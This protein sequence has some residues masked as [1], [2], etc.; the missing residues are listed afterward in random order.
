[1][2]IAWRVLLCVILSILLLYAMAEK[3]TENAASDDETS[4]DYYICFGHYEQDND[5]F[6]GPE[7]I[8]WVILDSTDTNMMLM[9]LYPLE[10]L[11]YND[12][13]EDVTWQKSTI[14]EWLNDTF[15][16]TAFYPEEQ[17][18]IETEIVD[19]D[20]NKQNNPQWKTSGGKYT[21]D[22]VF[23]LSYAEYNELIGDDKIELSEYVKAKGADGLLKDN[24]TWWLRSPG[25]KQNCACFAG[26]GKIE[27]GAVT[28]K[29]CIVPV[30]IVNYVDYDWDN[31]PYELTLRAFDLCNQG[32]YDRSIEIVDTLGDYWGSIYNRYYYRIEAGNALMEKGDYEGAKVR[33]EEAKAIIYN[34]FTEEDNAE[35]VKML[36]NVYSV[37][38]NLNEC[39]YQIALK[40]KES[41][42]YNRAIEMLTGIGSYKDSMKLLLDCFE[43]NH[44]RWSWLT[45]DKNSTVNAGTDTGYSQNN[46]IKDN[47]PHNGWHLGR[48]MVSGYT[49]RNDAGRPV[50][51][52]TPGDNVVLW[53]V[54][55]EDIDALNGNKNLA[56]ARD[57]NGSDIQFQEPKSDFGR[58]TLF[59][60]HENPRTHDT[61]TQKYKNFLAASNGTG[62][63]TRID[64]KEEGLYTVALDYEI[65][66]RN[67]IVVVD[68]DDYFNYR[69]AFS[70][71]VKN[72]SG[73]FFLFDNASGAELQDYSIAENG[74]RIDL[75]NSNILTVSYKRYNLNSNR[76]GLDE[77]KS[78][79]ATNGDRFDKQG[80][81]EITATNRETQEKVTKYV[82]VGNKD[83][84]QAYIEAD[85]QRLSKYESR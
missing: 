57:T 55:E 70:F 13:K 35:F 61:D 9:S 43:Q 85:P 27:S 1:M 24:T 10:Y 62:A 28:G 72:G 47:D 38:N 3:G 60:S 14:R 76:T 50:I 69:I 31:S 41:G 63:N 71:E 53:F 15:Y 11:P 77:R 23:L 59:I 16:N 33:F 17:A 30:I 26:N 19:N 8:E 75:A 81:Y 56:I 68:K 34:T 2:K 21:E 6:S 20:S 78:E 37:S 18:V 44:T 65:R 83:D 80:Y 49:E 67:K 40:A 52:K 66:R 29:R 45:Y 82:F 51:I 12:E 36:E 39:I 42:D 84:L 4:E 79:P 25:K 32:D 5:V 64:L 74:F 46:P 58:G 54:L 48:F 7:P 22:K 73:M